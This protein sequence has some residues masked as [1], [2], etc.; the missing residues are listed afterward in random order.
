MNTSNIDWDKELITL[1]KQTN[2]SIKPEACKDGVYLHLWVG[3][4]LFMDIWNTVTEDLPP[5]KVKTE[6][7]DIFIAI[8]LDVILQEHTNYLVSKHNETN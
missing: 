7:V 4:D 5:D 1:N 2:I 6:A 3:K 8:A